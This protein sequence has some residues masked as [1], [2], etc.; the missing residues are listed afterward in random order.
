M[1]YTEMRNIG[2]GGFAKVTLVINGSGEQFA[3]KTYAPLH[4]LVVAVG[5]IHLK[6]RFI[7]EVKYQSSIVHPHVVK[8]I[9]SELQVDPPFF[10]MPLAECSLKEE[11][12][13]NPTLSG[14]PEKALFDILAGLEALHSEGYV[15]RDLKPAN[16][17]KFRDI[18]G[19]ETYAIS[20]FGLMTATLGDSSTLTG[21]NA[22]GGTENYAA[23]ELIGNF[24]KA[25]ASADIYSFG[26]ILH[27]IF[28]NS[29]QRVPY[30]E[31]TLPGPMGEIVEKCTKKLAIRRYASVAAL[32][33]DLYRVLNTGN[34]QFNSTGEEDVVNL[35]NSKAGLTDDE[36]DKVFLLIE[37]NFDVQLSSGN[38]Y[39]SITADH[40]IEL[41]TNAPELFAAMGQ[42]YCDYIKNG[43]FD[44]DYCDIL[45][46]KAE[47]FY[48]KGELGLKSNAVLALLELGTT[49]NRW[50]VEQ[51]FMTMAG[52]SISEHLANR[53][54]VEVDVQGIDFSRKIAHVERSIGTSR[55]NLHPILQ[56][57]CEVKT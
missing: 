13:T 6:R 19:Q 41:G 11:R 38:I 34:I 23:P 10:I 55:T 4:Q 31:L 25:T 49:H 43:N 1:A 44:F 51:K 40:I 52:Q 20:D 32:R 3:K 12:D 39:A 46:S 54:K 33:D 56:E 27:D 53:I 8:I 36:W 29:A 15:H 57:L 5:D 50:Y 22:Q 28:G 24:R 47:I 35:L 26:A 17:L 42:Y 21:T 45:A 16:V 14:T 37:S 18:A 30:T 2:Q 7:R 48:E 9:D